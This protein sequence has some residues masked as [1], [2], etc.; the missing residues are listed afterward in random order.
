MDCEFKT[1]L[2]GF[3]KLKF[4]TGLRKGPVLDRLCEEDEGAELQ[5]MVS[6]AVKRES[7]VLEQ[8]SPAAQPINSLSR[9]RQKRSANSEPATSSTAKWGQQTRRSTG[10]PPPVNRSPK[11]AGARLATSAQ[12][13]RCFA[14]NQPHLISS[15]VNIRRIAAKPATSLDTWRRLAK[16]RKPNF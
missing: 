6:L 15:A 10:A 2:P 13:P 5:T 11:V 12:A 4:V 9:R 14:C 3:L 16:A 1:L 8:R 7:A